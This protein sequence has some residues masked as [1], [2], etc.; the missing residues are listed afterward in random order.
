MN[1]DIK[2]PILPPAQSDSSQLG[3]DAAKGVDKAASGV[4]DIANNLEGMIDRGLNTA[5]EKLDDF[6]KGLDNLLGKF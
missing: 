6:I 3:D 2:R 4:D 5:E 1:D